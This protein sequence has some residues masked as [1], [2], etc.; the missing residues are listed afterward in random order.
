MYKRQYISFPILDIFIRSGDIRDR[1]LKWSEIDLN[2]ACFWPPTFFGGGR[3]KIWDLVYKNELTSD[4]VA[5]FRGDR[6]TE[7]GDLAVKKNITSKT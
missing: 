7:L 4:Q 3:L 5:K 6:P 1:T 2:V